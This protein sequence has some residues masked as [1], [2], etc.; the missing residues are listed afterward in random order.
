[1]INLYRPEGML[2]G[3]LQNR[4]LL[5]M[6]RLG[7]EKA[8]A[9]GA[10]VESVATLCDSDMNLHVDLGGIDGIIPRDEVCY[11]YCGE[12]TKDIAIITRVGKAVCFKV[13]SLF[14]KDGKLINNPSTKDADNL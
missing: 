11:S 1:M 4:E 9:S 10:I 3:T 5:S 12:Q 6:G 14:E 8:I 2:I 7:L 13:M